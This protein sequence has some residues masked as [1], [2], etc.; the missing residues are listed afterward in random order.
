MDK[1]LFA[2]GILYIQA[3][4]YVVVSCSGSESDEALSTEDVWSE[5]GI[6]LGTEFRVSLADDV[7]SW[8]GLSRPGTG[9]PV[10]PIKMFSRT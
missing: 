4:L 7:G 5:L 1:L 3:F 8:L 6:L 10:R 2:K 9:V